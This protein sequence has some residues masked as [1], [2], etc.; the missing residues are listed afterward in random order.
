M[1]PASP[2]PLKPRV[3]RALTEC[4]RYCVL[5]M[6]LAVAA[7][8]V[9]WMVT[10]GLK[11][12]ADAMNWWG[13][14]RS[15]RVA[16][17]AE[18]WGTGE[19]L[20]Y[21]ANS[22]AVTAGAVALTLGLAAPAGYAVARLRFRGRAA[23]FAM[24]VAGMMVPV[25]VT[26]IPLLKFLESLGLYDT[27]TGLVM[28]YAAFSL[29]VAIVLFASFFREV[30]REL[31]E[32]AALDGCGAWGQFLHVALPVAR[33]AVLG[34][35]MLTLVNVWNDFV[36]ALVLLQDPDKATLPLGVRNLQGEFGGNVPL[37]A[38]ALTVAVLPPLLVYALA[39]R[40]L[41]KGLTAGAVKG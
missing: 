19:F 22:V 6:A 12:P 1:S 35:A 11:G 15:I 3:E 5:V 17:F 18:V 25:H 10:T 9:F 16:N 30:P 23:V 37:M 39:Q 2:R 13:L 14:P 27:R 31:E 40:H 4:G 41:V 33:P 32:A 29:P 36:F 28:V 21:F 20:R 34:V 26:L 7:Y 38:A 8:P 24:F